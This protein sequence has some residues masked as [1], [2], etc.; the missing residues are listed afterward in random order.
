MSPWAYG[1]SNIITPLLICKAGRCQQVAVSIIQVNLICALRI[2]NRYA[3]RKFVGTISKSTQRKTAGRLST[4]I[5][6]FDIY[7]YFATTCNK[8][9][10]ALIT[11]TNV[12]RYRLCWLNWLLLSFSR[13]CSWRR[14]RMRSRTITGTGSF[15][16]GLIF[17][18]CWLF[19]REYDIASLF[20][21]GATRRLLGFC[22]LYTSPSPRD[23][24]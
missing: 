24:R 7:G 14:S 15:C 19:I 9:D 5:D 3:W 17:G 22:L 23:T 4:R 2:C 16:S 21:F 10:N 1:Y 12:G 11:R 18:N 20:G 13:R 6:E 8:L